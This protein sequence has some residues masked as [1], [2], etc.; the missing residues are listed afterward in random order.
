MTKNRDIISIDFDDDGSDYLAFE[1]HINDHTYRQKIVTFNQIDKMGDMFLN[2][3]ETKKKRLDL[4]KV[5]LIPYILK[6]AGNK[7]S[8]NELISYSYGDVLHI[9]TETKEQYKS[10]IMEFFKFVFNL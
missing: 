9:H 6:K 10:K 2:E 7:Y 8:Y 1:K 4:K 3:I 5:N